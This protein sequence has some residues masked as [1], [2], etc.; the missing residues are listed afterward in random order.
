MKTILTAALLALWAQPLL[1]QRSPEL[2][3]RVVDQKTGA[4]V[5]S[6]R[7]EISG[8]R[9]AGLTSSAGELRIAGLEPRQHLVSVERVGYTYY[10]FIAD[11]TPG[12]TLAVDVELE[13]VPIELAGVKATGVRERRALRD[14]GYYERARQGFARVL[15]RNAIDERKP[16]QMIDLFRGMLGFRVAPSGRS[17]EPT[18]FSARGAMSLGS[19]NSTCSPAIFVDGAP[20]P[21]SEL[22]SLSPRTVEAIEAYP[23]IAGVPL[24]YSAN[25]SPC[26]SVFIWTRL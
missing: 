12:G 13:P 7:I 2:V 8:Q 10:Q 15:D 26:G 21:A 22:N 19:A 14:V 18:L 9:R 23:G 11:M 1:A 6:A 5:P 24:R 25:P 3:I 20:F 4:A 17:S 16:L